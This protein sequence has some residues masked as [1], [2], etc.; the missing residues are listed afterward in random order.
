M[1]IG[2]VG[3]PLAGKTTFFNLLTGASCETGFAG[4]GEVHLGSAVVPDARIDFLSGLYKPRKTIYAQ[5]QFKDIP[6]V[7]SDEGAASLAV[8]LLDEVRG[9]DALVQVVRAFDSDE[10]SSVAGEPSPYR[11]LSDFAA[12]LLLADM[13]A[14]E[15]RIDRIK[16]ARKMPKDAAAQLAVLERLLVALENEQPVSSVELSQAEQAIMAGQSFLTEKPLILAV[17][18]DED[19]MAAGD[20][21]DRDKVRAYASERGIPVIEVCARIEMEI[22]QLPAQDRA[23]FIT[24][25]GLTES[26]VGRLAQA[27][28]ERLGLISFFTVGEDEVRAWTIRRGTIAKKA[29]GKVHSDI[30]RGFIR[31]EVFHYEDLRE[32]GN[33]VKVKEKGLFRLEGKEY[34]VKDGDIINFRFNV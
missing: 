2:L 10:V 1:Q 25:L 11:E 8:K 3:L 14:I 18:I 16:N 26:G 13:G 22:S 5:I 6:G 23:D 34:V 9:A 15:N 29:A 28:Y 7:R 27:A 33:Q 24:D 21:P 4:T 20:Y 12:E 17:N 31:A 32:L 30:E 19:Q